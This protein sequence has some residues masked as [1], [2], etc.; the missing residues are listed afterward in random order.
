MRLL[1]YIGLRLHKYFISYPSKRSSRSKQHLKH[2]LM[3]I[4]NQLL[5][6]WIHICKRLANIIYAS[7]IKLITS[8]KIMKNCDLNCDNWYRNLKLCM[9]LHSSVSSVAISLI[10]YILVEKYKSARFIQVFCMLSSMPGLW[11]NQHYSMI[12]HIL[13]WCVWGFSLMM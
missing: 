2:M 5:T 1:T 4:M 11:C 6:N 3:Q 10:L 9:Y 12:E 8:V 7:L 13:V